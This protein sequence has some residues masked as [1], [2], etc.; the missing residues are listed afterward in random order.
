MSHLG[1]AQAHELVQA[2]L[3][4][5]AVGARQVRHLQANVSDW[6]MTQ[7][8][9][10]VPA[11]LHDVSPALFC[12][13]VAWRTGPAAARCSCSIM[14]FL[15]GSISF[16]PQAMDAK[17]MNGSHPGLQQ[18][19]GEVVGSTAS[20]L[21]LEI[22]AVHASAAHVPRARHDVCARLRLLPASMHQNLPVALCC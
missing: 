20:Q 2:L 15:S 5:Q 4:V 8:A 13:W 22:P 12:S 7:H 3:A 10:M 21:A 19:G 6:P 9:S 1:G 17:V 11:A 16:E 14:T 18:R